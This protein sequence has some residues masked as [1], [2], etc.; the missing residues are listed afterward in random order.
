MKNK[1]KQVLCMFAICGL[2]FLP[3]CLKEQEPEQISDQISENSDQ[4]SERITESTLSVN[5]AAGSPAR[6][7]ATAQAL[8]EVV[9]AGGN[10]V[11]DFYAPWCGPCKMMSPIV[12]QLS[13]ERDDIT[14][15]KVNID[16]FDESGSF[17][18]AGR[19]VNVASIP[20]FFLFKNGVFVKEFDGGMDKSSFIDKIDTSLNNK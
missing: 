5:T 1:S 11:V 9:A 19:Q 16:A 20:T 10:V 8:R 4:V 18:L 12:D 6:T 7:L 15:V 17:E 2:L 13:A 3:S 14:F